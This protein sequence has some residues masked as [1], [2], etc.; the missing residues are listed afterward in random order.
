MDWRVKGAIQ[1]VL[2]YMPGGSYVHHAL[3]RR[4]GGLKDFARECDTKIDD[5]RLM[6]GHLQ[7]AGLDVEGATLVEVGT[8]WYPTF[9]FCLY[10][11]GAGFVHT[12]DLQRLLKRDMVRMLVERLGWQRAIVAKVS[13]RRDAELQTRLQSLAHAVERG[14]TLADATDGVVA[15]RAPADAARTA[16]PAGSVDAVFSNSVLEHVPP[17]EIER[18]FGEA[19]RIL[20]PG[21]V[22]FHSV[23]CGDHY[24][25]VDPSIDQL[26]YLQ[27]SDDAWQRWN[28]PFLYQNRLR[29]RDF[30]DLARRAGFT[31]ELDTSRP[32]PERLAR[33]DALR[34][35]PKF[36]VYTREQLA[37]TSIDFIARKPT[38]PSARE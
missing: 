34:V 29:A 15:Y 8:G 31:I 12:F 26:H 38:A 32:S 25:Y 37:I 14:A 6:M 2:G 11:C 9:P 7:Q 1:K 20:R 36:D 33:L 35:D 30:I 19:M 22:M 10:L 23:N 21:G 24:A 5:W 27:Y 17:P 3:Q 28:N 13:G 16:L 4:A 18:I